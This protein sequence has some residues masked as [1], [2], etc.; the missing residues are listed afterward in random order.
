MIASAH[1]RSIGSR[2]Q[3]TRS[4]QGNPVFL[5]GENN[6]MLAIVWNIM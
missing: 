4:F 5:F 1:P 2:E 6:K 3:L